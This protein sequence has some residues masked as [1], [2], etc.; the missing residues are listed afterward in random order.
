M[1]AANEHL[2]RSVCKEVK[3]T[4]HPCSPLPTSISLGPSRWFAFGTVFR[5]RA[6]S[7]AED[8]SRHYPS[9]HRFARFK[10]FERFS[11]KYAEP[12]PWLNMN[13]A[14]LSPH[15]LPGE[16]NELSGHR[17]VSSI[18]DDIIDSEMNCANYC[19]DLFKSRS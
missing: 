7:L 5:P 9:P 4:S 3:M 15:R 8:E 1:L 18:C 14:M 6:H 13:L 10:M 16:P 17:M 11:M 19:M 12:I 2:S